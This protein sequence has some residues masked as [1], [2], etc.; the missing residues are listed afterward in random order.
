MDRKMGIISVEL[1][2][3]DAEFMDLWYKYIRG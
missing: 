1:A 2:F 3:R